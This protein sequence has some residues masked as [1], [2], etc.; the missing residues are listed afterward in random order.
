MKTRRSPLADKP[1]HLPGQSLD[2]MIR[3][4]EEEML[5]FFIYG[6]GF[7]LVAI[8]AWYQWLTSFPLNPFVG[9]FVALM[10]GIYCAYRIIRI[11]NSI[12]LYKLGRDGEIIVA[13]QLDVVKQQGAA[14][15]HDIVADK[16][17]IDHVILSKKGIFVAET[18]TMTKPLKGSPPVTYDGKTLLINGFKPKR[19]PIPQVQ[20]N[21][22]WIAKALFESTGKKYS[23]K[24]VILFPGWY[25]ESSL[26][27]DIWVLEPKALPTLIEKQPDKISDSDLHLAVYFLT[28]LV[29]TM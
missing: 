26:H 1:M 14:I 8:I 7:V 22:R 19:D 29:R 16:F 2:E 20:A 28:R 4:K 17:N 3:S 5:E 24:S 11:R 12:R 15:I 25:C 18:K 21:S 6:F 9:T 13:E 10:I 27:S 23:V